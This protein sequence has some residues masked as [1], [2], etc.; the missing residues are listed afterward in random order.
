MIVYGENQ[1]NLKQIDWWKWATLLAI[2]GLLILKILE[3]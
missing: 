1:M 2:I 3:G